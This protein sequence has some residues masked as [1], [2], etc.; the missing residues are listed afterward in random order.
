[1]K[2]VNH[3]QQ[4]NPERTLHIL[5]LDQ[6][7]TAVLASL[8]SPGSRR[9]YEHAIVFRNFVMKLYRLFVSLSGGF[10]GRRAEGKRFRR[11][12]LRP[13][14]QPATSPAIMAAPTMKSVSK[15]GH[16]HR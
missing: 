6:A 13:G 8:R 10:R 5:D 15:V 3:G 16:L 12:T 11:A 4:E 14:P 1:M 2:K 9:C 7:K